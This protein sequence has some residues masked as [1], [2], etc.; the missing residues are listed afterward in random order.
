MELKLFWKSFIRRKGSLLLLVLI[1]AASYG[2]LLRSAEYLSVR[3]EIERISREYRPV[4]TLSSADGFV[5][6]AALLVQESSYV[7]M[8]DRNRACPAILSDVYNADVDGYSSDNQEGDYAYGVRVSSL[9]AWGEVVRIREDLKKG[10]NRYDFRITEGVY[11]Y[12]EYIQEGKMLVLE[13]PALAPLLE[14]GKGYL[15]QGFPPTEENGGFYGEG[16]VVRLSQMAEGVWFLEGEPDRETAWQYIDEQALLQERNRHAMLAIT[17][18]DMRLLP[19]VQESSRDFYLEEGR[20]L[21]RED[22]EEGRRVCMV[23]KEFADLRGLSIGDMLKMTLQ[24]QE[25]EFLGYTLSCE[26]DTWDTCDKTEI[27]LEIVGIYGRLYGGMVGGPGYAPLSQRSIYVYMPDSC[28][29]EHYVSKQRNEVLQDS[30]SFVLA[31]PRDKNAFIQDMKDILA[32][33]GCTVTFVENNWDNFYQSAQAVEQGGFYSFLVFAVVMTSALGVSAFL[34]IWQRKNEIA[35]A[36]AMGVP[37]K[38]AVACACLPML[39]LEGA[40]LLLGGGLGWRYGITRAGTTL[41][42]LEAGEWTVPSLAWFAGISLL[43]WLMSA[44]M[45]LGGSL[46]WARKPV[47]SILR[48]GGD[49]FQKA[50]GET[51]AQDK[52]AV[53]RSSI[54]SQKT[55]GGPGEAR[56][57][58]RKTAA[59]SVG[60]TPLAVLIRF[61]RRHLFRFS[62]RAVFALLPAAVF[63]VASCWL[64]YSIEAGER[65]I[66]RLFRSIV[67]DAQIGKMNDAVYV[68]G[69]GG[70]Y[71]S[72]ETIEKFLDTGFVK[73]YFQVAGASGYVGTADAG[74][75]EKVDIYGIADIEQYLSQPGSMIQVCYGE[76]YGPELFGE[77]YTQMDA[78]GLISAAPAILPEPLWEKWGLRGGEGLLISD[79]KK[80][81][82][83]GA[84]AGGFYSESVGG[85]ESGPL[86]MPMSFLELLEKDGLYYTT[87]KLILDPEKNQELDEFRQK[88]QEIIDAPDAGLQSLSLV[89]WDGELRQAVV[90]M[91]K[92][93]ALMKVLYPIANGVA[94]L[95]AAGLSILFLF[96]RRREAAILRVLGVGRLPTRAVL[97]LELLVVNLLG[98]LL[99]AVLT[100][101]LTGPEGLAAMPLAAGCYFLGC[102]I[103]TMAG[104]MLVTSGRP[105]ELLQEKE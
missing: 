23:M 53:D 97:A 70:A 65:E 26:T 36:R 89:I 8:T 75:L 11:G 95:A 74:K 72:R 31:D 15:V 80:E 40:V 21:T 47:L 84:V 73:E 59:S 79:S 60:R 58:A 43:C 92:N 2:F 81:M 38:K 50:A 71:I 90:P 91:E 54:Y 20:W 56:P 17:T 61:I 83:V 18:A 45:L 27:T 67:V 30:F 48:G 98:G 34:Y 4:G 37:V 101:F 41:A 7:E 96:Q 1:A 88:S 102:L 14:E 35:I 9:M 69:H 16:M 85:Q 93:I 64:W 13:V 104:A 49:Q 22:Q 103:G 5:T 57:L 76:G 28:L 87:A 25:P 68:D 39:A 24:D 3:G 44:M 62:M 99:G 105:L 42:A 100:R 94:F 12:P 51:P 19:Q 46:L 63:L 33:L 52:G 6:D 77:D 66:S 82:M 10:V 29:P 86:L 55:A 78:F 32:S